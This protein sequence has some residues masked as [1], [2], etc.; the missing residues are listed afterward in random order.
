MSA[1][2]AEETWKK[3]QAAYADS[4]LLRRLNLLRK[5]FNSKLSSFNN[6]EAYVS[7]IR[8]TQQQLIEVNEPVDDEFV[9]LIMLT[10]LTDQYN[11]C[12]SK[13]YRLIDPHKPRAIIVA[14]DVV[15]IE[16][17]VGN[18]VPAAELTTPADTTLIYDQ[19]E[20][21]TLQPQRPQPT[22]NHQPVTPSV[23]PLQPTS[24]STPDTQIDS[25]PEISEAETSQEYLTADTESSESAPT[26]PESD[27]AINETRYPQ[28]QRRA[29]DRYSPSMFMV[30]D[31]EPETYKQAVE[32]A[33]SSEWQKAMQ[34]E[35]DCLMKH[36]TWELVERPTDR[37]VIKNKWVYKIK[38]NTNGEVVKFKARLVAK[39]FTQV[40]GIDYGETFSP[41]ARLS[42]VRLLLAF[43]VQ[44]NVQLDHL[45]VETAFLNGDLEEEIFMEQPSGFEVNKKGKVCL[46]KNRF[47]V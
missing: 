46:L 33:H 39:G 10:G 2:T 12:E 43:A 22:T 21:D 47:M 27:S 20:I 17:K 34:N 6:M 44:L 23:S 38:K 36:G 3:L 40:H 7:E 24:I 13:G 30:S 25:L 1:L 42:S 9:G 14:R 45:D 28:R 35:Y 29:P 37:K 26:S 16:D 8:A 18:P 31:Y 15:F 19:V 32:D 4:G 11:P 5:L 41:V